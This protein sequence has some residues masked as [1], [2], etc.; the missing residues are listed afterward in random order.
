MNLF[1]ALRN[2]WAVAALAAAAAVGQAASTAPHRHQHSFGRTF[3]AVPGYGFGNYG[4]GFGGPGYYTGGYGSYGDGYGAPAFG[5]GSLNADLL[6]ENQELR[7]QRDADATIPR[8][9]PGAAAKLAADRRGAAKKDKARQ[10]EKVGRALF[11]AG[12][13][14]RAG[15]RW[16]EALDADPEANRHFLLAQAKFAQKRFAEAAQEVRNGLRT[17]PDWATGRFDVRTLYAAEGDFLGQLAALAAEV[18]ANPLDRDA[19]YLFGYELYVSGRRA[20]AKTVLEAAL[21]ADA[22]A[23]GIAPF[24]AATKP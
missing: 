22:D 8:L 13:Y 6:R 2:S 19:L 16:K 20:D 1:Q 10:A 15:E 11:V 7:R 4:Y 23:E 14:R 9:D 12:Q 3:V 17:R 21:K 24:L 5:Y 18:K